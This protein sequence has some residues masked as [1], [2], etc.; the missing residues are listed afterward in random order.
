[1]STCVQLIIMKFENFTE[2]KLDQLRTHSFHKIPQCC[3]LGQC[4]FTIIA[5]GFFL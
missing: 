1:M 2:I 4:Q 3:Q 5:L